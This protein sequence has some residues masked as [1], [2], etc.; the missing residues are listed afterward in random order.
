MAKSLKRLRRRG[1]VPTTTKRRKV[2]PVALAMLVGGALH[3]VVAAAI[4][5]MSTQSAIATRLA[6]PPRVVAVIVD[7]LLEHKLVTAVR[8]DASASAYTLARPPYA[9]VVAALGTAFAA[10]VA[11]LD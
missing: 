4:A 10:K 5:P 2:D 1:A 7:S 8:L 11:T 6:M 9:R 3:A